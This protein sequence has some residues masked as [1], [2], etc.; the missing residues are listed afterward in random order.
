VK[1]NKYRISQLTTHLITIQSKQINSILKD[2]SDW[3]LLL[4]IDTQKAD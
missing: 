1:S 3:L 2:Q 4:A